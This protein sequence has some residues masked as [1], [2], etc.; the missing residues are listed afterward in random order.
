MPFATDIITYI[1]VPLAVLGVLPI[2]YSTL[3]ALI[4]SRRIKL[5]LSR[6]HVYPIT[7]A[8]LMSQTVELEFSRYSITPLPRH[9]PF[10]WSDSSIATST[11][12]GGAWTIFNWDSLVTGHVLTRV[13]Y[14]D[15]IRQPQAEVGFE[16]LVAF[17][18]DRGAVVDTEGWGRLKLAGLWTPGGT[19]L[20]KAPVGEEEAV[21]MVKRPD[22]SDGMV[23]LGLQWKSEWGGRRDEN[24]LPPYWMRVEGFGIPIEKEDSEEEENKIVEED[25]KKIAPK[26]QEEDQ[27]NE[28]ENESQAPTEA[29][30]ID[31]TEQEKSSLPLDRPPTPTRASIRFR[32]STNGIAAAYHETSSQIAIL[33]LA[34]PH[35]ILHNDHHTPAGLWFAS[36]ATAVSQRH[37]ATLWSYTIPPSLLNFASKLSI[38]CGVLVLLNL[39]DDKDTPP[40]QTHYDQAAERFELLEQH[41]RS[42]MLR[43]A[44]KAMKHAQAAA[45]RASREAEERFELHRNVRKMAQQRQE[46]EEKRIVEAV[47][48]PRLDNTVVAAA[49]SKA[50]HNAENVEEIL[51]RMLVDE[52]FATGLAALLET[53]KT[54]S[55]SGGM[56]R[57]H[58]DLLSKQKDTFFRASLLVRVL[59]EVHAASNNGLATDLREATKA[60]PKVRLG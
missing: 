10:Y 32:L 22:E 49:C 17:L 56:T 55:E 44:E 3:S 21:L 12:P 31:T 45:A 53:W 43:Q 4:V 15:E 60:W 59:G 34:T 52:P 36:A 30:T 48:S 39:M 50:L 11:L 6:S 54:W 37:S 38:P 26:Y 47:N 33:H 29:T 42:S 13:T 9:H 25:Q 46:R 51:Y 27:K 18:L 2:I 40:W 19:K 57:E 14:V 7:R 41:Q 24:S 20:L 35:L 5:A 8:S 16:E 23:S 1:G 58:M 28:A